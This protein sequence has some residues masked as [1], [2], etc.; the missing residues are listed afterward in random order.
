M[1]ERLGGARTNLEIEQALQRRQLIGTLVCGEVWRVESGVWGRLMQQ[2]NQSRSTEEGGTHDDA[3]SA[4]V[5][6]SLPSPKLVTATAG[7]ACTNLL[8]I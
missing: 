1:G 7:P 4:G 2:G 5:K 3:C 8:R 6:K